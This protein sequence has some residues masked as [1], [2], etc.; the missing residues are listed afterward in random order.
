MNTKSPIR[1]QGFIE[2]SLDTSFILKN[3]FLKLPSSFFSIRSSCSL[4]GMSSVIIILTPLI[5]FDKYLRSQY[6]VY[7]LVTKEFAPPLK[8]NQ[9]AVYR[10][11]VSKY[12]LSSIIF[13]MVFREYVLLSKSLVANNS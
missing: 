4:M 1:R 11:G 10:V 12:F 13:L 2:R 6:Y 7:S 9:S 3:L 8:G 5:F